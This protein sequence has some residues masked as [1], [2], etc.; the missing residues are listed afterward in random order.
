MVTRIRV[1]VNVLLSHPQRLNIEVNEMKEEP[2]SNFVIGDHKVSA[3]VRG[4]S[5]VRF[6]VPVT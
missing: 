1:P 3:R 6:S 4:I 2:V 5:D